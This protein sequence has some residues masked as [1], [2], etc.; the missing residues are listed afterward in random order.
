M[1]KIKVLDTS[2][3]LETWSNILYF[4]L[5]FISIWTLSDFWCIFTHSIFIST[6]VSW[7]F[8][9]VLFLFGNNLFGNIFIY[10]RTSFKQLKQQ[11]QSNFYDRQALFAMAINVRIFLRVLSVSIQFLTACSKC[12]SCSR[13]GFVVVVVVL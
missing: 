1:H 10:F 3:D 12:K 7:L 5:L 13:N 2:L 9:L 8:L 11:Q 4:C 6:T